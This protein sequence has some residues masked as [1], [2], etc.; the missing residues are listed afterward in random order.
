[1][2]EPLTWQQRFGQIFA[3]DWADVNLRDGLISLAVLACIIG[4]RVVVGPRVF[5]AAIAA[6]FVLILSTHARHVWKVVLVAATLGAIVTIS[7]S[8]TTEGDIAAVTFIWVV[9]FF[10]SLT[11]TMPLISALAA[12]INIWAIVA[13]NT[14]SSTD[15]ALRGG[16]AWILGCAAGG[17]VLWFRARQGHHREGMLVDIDLKTVTVDSTVRPAVVYFASVRATAVAIAAVI[18]LV[19]FDAHPWWAAMAALVVAGINPEE[20]KLVAWQR[21]VGTLLGAVVAS[22]LL[23]A[24]DESAVSAGLVVLV[25]FLALLFRTANQAIFAAGITSL[26][27]MADSLLGGAPFKLGIVRVVETL[28]GIGLA[29]MVRPLTEPALRQIGAFQK[30]RQA[31]RRAAKAAPETAP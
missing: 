19:I 11:V 27:I 3:I 20:S 16:F 30:A 7:A 10:A 4:A 23:Q 22:L 14:A 2:A 6:L 24:T 21:A 5:V 1:M 18:G 26:F 29:L 25:A 31:A 9:T 12:L 13:M 28:I 8:R 17:L 15:L